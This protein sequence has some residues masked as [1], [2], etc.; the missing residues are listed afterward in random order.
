MGKQN[1]MLIGVNNSNE[2]VFAEWKVT[3]RN[4][5]P[6]FTASFDTVAPFQYDEETALER[7]E[8]SIDCWDGESKFDF[9]E[10]H[11]CKPSE[12][13]EL[14]L[15]YDGMEYAYDTSL[16]P[17]NFYINGADIYFE[18]V[19]CGQHDVRDNNEFDVN[20]PFGGENVRMFMPVEDL[21]FLL[22]TW[23]K[24][25]LKEIPEEVI[26]E[27]ENRFGKYKTINELDWI[28]QWLKEEWLV[29]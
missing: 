7:I 14:I 27:L 16:Y 2:L 8:S 10:R 29:N 24:Y 15:R 3:Y 18:S 21:T 1:K 22:E 11:D 28:E 13:A 25:H 12:M 19:G 5:Y 23:D 20:N 6:E 17:D 26:V 9:C 4:G